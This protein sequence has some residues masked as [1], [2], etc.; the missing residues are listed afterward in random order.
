MD[1][2][3][4]QSGISIRKIEANRENAKRSTGP[5]TAE[6][7]GNSSR[8]AIKHGLLSKQLVIPG[9]ESHEDF[10][11]LLKELIEDL[12]PRGRAELSI[13]ELIA[14]SDFRF[15]RSLRAEKAD[16]IGDPLLSNPLAVSDRVL[17]SAAQMN[18]ILR[19]QTMIHRQKMQSFQLLE[20]LQQRR[21]SSVP[22]SGDS[23]SDA[24]K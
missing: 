6:G 3:N 4:P 8:N 9:K 16:I 10:D 20:K 5:R 13:V 22:T 24:E 23:E 12:Q 7:K 11:Q 15:L 1:N 21:R 18:N 19:Y 2:E 14:S 17:P